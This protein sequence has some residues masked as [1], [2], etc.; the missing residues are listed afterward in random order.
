MKRDG[1]AWQRVPLGDAEIEYAEHGEGDPI[2]L[3]HAGVFGAWFDPVYA[4]PSLEGFRVILV[5]RAGYGATP[6]LGHVTLQEHARHAALLAERLGL[7]RIH[8]VGHSSS[9]LIGLQLAVDRPDLLHSL[10]LLEPAPGGALSVPAHEEIK[11]GL[12]ALRSMDVPTAFDAFMRGVGGDDYR[13]VLEARLGPAGYERA[14]RDAAFFFADEMPAV[15]EWQFE[16]VDAGRVRQPALIVEGGESHRL[17]PMTRQIIACAAALL[18]HAE[19]ATLAGVNHLMPLQDPEA[20]ARIIAAF[21][22]RH[23]V[24]PSLSSALEP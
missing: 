23:P 12:G 15:W 14:V 4:S 2:F 5:R 17:S 11:A 7:A 1:D 3:V 8:Y 13:R 22:R 19:V 21:A 24:V 20:I 9:C 16:A 18:P 10:I 6:P